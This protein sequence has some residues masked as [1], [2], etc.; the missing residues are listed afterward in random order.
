MARD[1]QERCSCG[2]GPKLASR[3]QIE[4]TV[5]EYDNRHNFEAAF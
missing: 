3:Q 2:N 4:T 1:S 5:Y